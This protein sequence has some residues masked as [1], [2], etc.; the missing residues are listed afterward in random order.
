VIRTSPVSPPAAR[1]TADAR[2]PLTPPRSEGL[3]YRLSA[4]H[5]GAVAPDPRARE[6][7]RVPASRAN[8]LGC[9]DPRDKPRLDP[10]S[11][12]P[13]HFSYLTLWIYS[14]ITYIT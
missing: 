7:R 14:Y 1:G 2:L 9:D 10:P 6:G 12:A 8:D 3:A 11:G 13:A 4:E 5:R